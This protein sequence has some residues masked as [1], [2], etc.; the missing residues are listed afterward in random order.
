MFAL[1]AL[2]EG[3]DQEWIGGFFQGILRDKLGAER[4][5]EP[6]VGEAHVAG[7]ICRRESWNLGRGTLRVYHLARD[8]TFYGLVIETPDGGEAAAD[9]VVR[10]FELID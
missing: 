1:C 4:R 6:S 10:G 2:E 9:A 7:Q 5:G 8:N 3:Q